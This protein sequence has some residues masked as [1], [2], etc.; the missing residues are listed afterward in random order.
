MQ[1]LLNVIQ[2]FHSTKTKILAISLN[3]EKAFDQVE[4][5]YLFHLMERFNLGDTFIS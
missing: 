1:R 4:W 3:A 5:E 2:Y